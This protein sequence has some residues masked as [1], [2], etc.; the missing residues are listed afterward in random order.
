MVRLLMADRFA[1]HFFH[2]QT[3]APMDR[4]RAIQ[5]R[6]MWPER[7]WSLQTAKGLEFYA[8]VILAL[9]LLP[10]LLSIRSDDHQRYFE[11]LPPLALTLLGICVLPL[12]VEL[13]AAFFYRRPLIRLRDM[14]AGCVPAVV[15]WYTYNR[16]DVIAP[17]AYQSP[18]GTC[19]QR[20]RMTFWLMILMSAFFSQQFSCSRN[21]LDWSGVDL[22]TA[23][24]HKPPN[25]FDDLPL[26][27]TFARSHL[28]QFEV[29]Q[30]PRVPKAPKAIPLPTPKLE[31]YQER[32]LERMPPD[33][34]EK[35]L[36]R[37]RDQQQLTPDAVKSP[38]ASSPPAAARSGKTDSDQLVT[39]RGAVS[40]MHFIAYWLLYPLAATL[41]PLLFVG[42][43]CFATTARLAG[44]FRPN[45]D[46]DPSDLLSAS[47]WQELLART[48]LRGRTRKA[49]LAVRGKCRRQHAGPCSA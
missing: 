28:A 47:R 41:F 20:R 37:L 25:N 29:K 30:Q 31:P 45:T 32:M 46:V 13:L 15:H 35:Y 48:P 40:L 18:A 17:G 36:Q 42:A 9:A 24:P 33:E 11:N 38:A 22:Q 34:R 2:L 4:T 16:H 6:G 26:P 39:F 49:Q 1:C 14:V 27:Q 7:L 5:L 3:T 8:V 43:F 10:W 21:H 19:K 44:Y 23:A 12:V